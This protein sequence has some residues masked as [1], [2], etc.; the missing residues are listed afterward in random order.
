MKCSPFNR[1]TIPDPTVY[2]IPLPSNPLTVS[3][4]TSASSIAVMKAL[5]QDADTDL[6][7]LR[8]FGFTGWDPLGK[9]ATPAENAKA[10]K[11]VIA[12]LLAEPLVE[13]VWRAVGF[14]VPPA[15]SA[16]HKNDIGQ[17]VVDWQLE[18][19]FLV[20]CSGDDD[21]CLQRVL[22][23]AGRYGQGAIFQYNYHEESSR[24]FRKTVP[25]LVPCD[26]ETVEVLL[27]KTSP[28]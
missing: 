24:L 4:T 13:K 12:S 6:F 27:S 10:N 23:I 8:L 11:A 2:V 21:Q 25:V 20:G 5:R 22:K 9:P 26:D 1:G 7:R 3:S 28:A 17:R 14:T 18:H 16:S 19:G 15:P